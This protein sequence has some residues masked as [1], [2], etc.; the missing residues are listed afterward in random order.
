MRNVASDKSISSISPGMEGPGSSAEWCNLVAHFVHNDN[1]ICFESAM[2]QWTQ[3]WKEAHVIPSCCLQTNLSC[4]FLDY[5]TH[6][7]QDI[8]H[9]NKAVFQEHVNHS[10]TNGC[11]SKLTFDLSVFDSW[12][13]VQ[14]YWEN[15]WWIYRCC[16][17]FRICLLLARFHWLCCGHC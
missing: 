5:C 1:I 8:D 7:W 4:T 3:P 10:D 15:I 6:Q 16:A 14:R 13:R 2:L 12:C 11:R 17:A 9:G